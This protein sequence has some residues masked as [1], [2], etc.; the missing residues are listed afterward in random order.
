MDIK[1]TSDLLNKLLSLTEKKAERKVYTCFIRVLS[2]LKS[3][4]LTESQSK[5]IREKLS[6][7]NLK[8][9]IEDRK[10]YFKQKLSDFTRFLKSEFSFT[11]EKY[12][13]E[14]GMVLGMSLGTGIGISIGVAIDPVIGI[15]IGLSIGTGIGMVLGMLY[16]TRKDAEAKKHGRVI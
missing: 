7:L 16:G 11:T 4:D 10:K 3:K 6:S 12:H 1:E 9:T 14:I 15:S 13:T 5:L 2:S 8:I